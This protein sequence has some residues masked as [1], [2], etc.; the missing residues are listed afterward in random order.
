MPSGGYS[1]RRWQRGGADRVLP[2]LWCEPG[3]GTARWGS[4]M[5]PGTEGL[6]P[7]PLA[8]EQTSSVS[9]T[10]LEASCC[11]RGAPAHPSTTRGPW[12]PGS[13]FTTSL[14]LDTSPIAK[15]TTRTRFGVFFGLVWF[16]VF[17]WQTPSNPHLARSRRLGFEEW[18]LNCCGAACPTP[19]LRQACAQHAALALPMPCPGQQLCFSAWGSGEPG[20]KRLKQI[21]AGKLQL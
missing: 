11:K 16:G 6:H 4:S 20:L 17:L 12:E 7:R 21:S 1:P 15:F 13:G 5:L 18:F 14:Q 3:S 10:T 2:A 8:A 19:E 9:H